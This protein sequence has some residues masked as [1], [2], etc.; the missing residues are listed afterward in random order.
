M[1][2]FNQPRK[3]RLIARQDRHSA[4]LPDCGPGGCWPTDRL[5]VDDGRHYF[6]PRSLTF[7]D[8][9]PVTT[10]TTTNSSSSSSSSSSSETPKSRFCPSTRRYKL[11]YCMLSDDEALNRMRQKTER[12]SST[13]NLS[14]R[15]CWHLALCSDVYRLLH[16]STAGSSYFHASD[17]SAGPGILS[18]FPLDISVFCVPTSKLR[19]MPSRL[20]SHEF[21]CK[22]SSA[23]QSS[24]CEDMLRI[25]SVKCRQPKYDIIQCNPL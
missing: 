3:R 4:A 7:I 20:L 25:L 15:T 2:G 6:G 1:S 19:F 13:I 18:I 8:R 23:D 21:S 9:F 12:S 14:Q 16:H 24:L 10:P 11:N 5:Y 22:F 17:R